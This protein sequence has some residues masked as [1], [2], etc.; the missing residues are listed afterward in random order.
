MLHVTVDATDPRARGEAYGAG[1]ADRL[2][3]VWQAYRS[4]FARY[5]GV[6][7]ATALR[8]GAEVLEVVDAWRPALRAELEGVATGGGIAIEA[9]GALNGRTEL[10]VAAECATVGRVHSPEGPW[11]AQN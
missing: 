7:E 6:D 9:V 8:V 11:L 10:V 2:P 4:L 5:A 1:V 3:L